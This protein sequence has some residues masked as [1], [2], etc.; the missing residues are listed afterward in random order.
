MLIV[1]P[2]A[3]YFDA[4]TA[5]LELKTRTASL[6]DDPLSVVPIVSDAPENINEDGGGVRVTP[7]QTSPL[8]RE[9]LSNETKFTHDICIPMMAVVSLNTHGDM[10]NLLSNW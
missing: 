2:D 6:R 5:A 1:T 7:S 10:T 9:P 8:H 4:M 3:V